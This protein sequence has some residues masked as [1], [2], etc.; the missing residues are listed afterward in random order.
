MNLSLE[1]SLQTKPGFEEI[2]AAPVSFANNEDVI[3]EKIE[4]KENH[5]YDSPLEQSEL[6]TIDTFRPIE[7]N[8]SQRVERRKEPDL[9]DLNDK[10]ASIN[11]QRQ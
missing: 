2:S 6:E 7:L 11:K 8:E 5:D 1:F 10:M 9:I 4:D 3:L